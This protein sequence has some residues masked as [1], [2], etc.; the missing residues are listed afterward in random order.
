M[1]VAK[2]RWNPETGYDYTCGKC[3]GTGDVRGYV[4]DHCYGVL[5]PDA[6]WS[7]IM[8][9]FKTARG[10]RYYALLK[11]ALSIKGKAIVDDAESY[12]ERGEKL[13]VAEIFHMMVRHE[14]PRIRAKA[15][16]EWLEET[17][18]IKTGIYRHMRNSGLTIK[19]ICEKLNI[20]IE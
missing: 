17:Y 11:A 15:F 4:C 2:G 1:P 6:Q 7:A 18:T 10:Q 12:K 19:G 13:T 16:F 8:S 9:A 20:P 14:W 5:K 3:A